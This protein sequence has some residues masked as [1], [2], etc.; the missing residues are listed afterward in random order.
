[1]DATIN[2]HD[3]DALLR[4][5]D[6]LHGLATESPREALLRELSRFYH[7]AREEPFLRTDPACRQACDLWIRYLDAELGRIETRA[8]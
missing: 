2:R 8:Q 1:M 5:L 6:A 7:A 3:N 4:A